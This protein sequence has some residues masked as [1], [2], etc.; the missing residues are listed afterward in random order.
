V[1]TD[2]RDVTRAAFDAIVCEESQLAR[3]NAL[4]NNFVP[5]TDVYIGKSQSQ[6]QAGSQQTTHLGG[7]PATRA[8]GRFCQLGG[9]FFVS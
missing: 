2:D 6:R 8:V 4:L 9:A 5:R 3:A 7:A 1:P